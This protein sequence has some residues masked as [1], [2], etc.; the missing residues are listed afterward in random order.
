MKLKTPPG[1]LFPRASSGGQG[2]GWMWGEEKGAGEGWT[3]A[4]FPWRGT[5]LN[6]QNPSVLRQ[7]PKGDQSHFEAAGVSF[8]CEGCDVLPK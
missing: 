3:S 8:V 2:W 4:G 7:V 1:P 5:F 6:I